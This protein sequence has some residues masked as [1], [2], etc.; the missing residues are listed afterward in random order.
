M[1]QQLLTPI[2]VGEILKISHQK[3]RDLARARK[4]SHLRVGSLY[5]FTQEDI[6]NYLKAEHIAQDLGI[7]S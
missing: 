6:D 5:R 2:E 1:E 7:K 3:V 4:L